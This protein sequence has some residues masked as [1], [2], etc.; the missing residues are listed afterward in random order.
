VLA[1]GDEGGF[2]QDKGD[3]IDCGDATALVEL[4]GGFIPAGGE[5]CAAAR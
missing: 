1:N 2:V 3:V 5:V 4:S